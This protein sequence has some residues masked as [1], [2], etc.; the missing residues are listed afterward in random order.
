MDVVFGFA[1][2]V[3]VMSAGALIAE[4]TVEEIKANERVQALYFGYKSA[5][6]PA[7]SSSTGALQA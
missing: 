6:E 5:L 1:D 3:L 2:R 7:R 4:G